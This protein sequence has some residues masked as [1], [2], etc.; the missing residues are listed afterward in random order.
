MFTEIH[1]ESLKSREAELRRAAARRRQVLLAVE[2]ARSTRRNDARGR[3]VPTKWRRDAVGGC[4]GYGA[5]PPRAVADDGAR[6]IAG[7]AARRR[8]RP[9]APRHRSAPHCR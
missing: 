3:V 6:R 2:A 1:Y 5:R 9:R 8:R 7:S 4:A